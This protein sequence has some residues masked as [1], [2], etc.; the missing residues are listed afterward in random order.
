MAL[1]YKE[2]W[3]DGEQMGPLFKN[4]GL[5]DNSFVYDKPQFDPNECYMYLDYDENAAINKFGGTDT[6]YYDAMA[7][8]FVYP[9]Y[10]PD[11]AD[12]DPETWRS[13]KSIEVCEIGM[14]GRVRLQPEHVD[15]TDEFGYAPV[16]NARV[17]VILALCL[18]H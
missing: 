17:R 8:P 4:K 9:K 14:K 1:D 3:G 10:H 12:A 18:S 15:V 7:I 11:L 6:K 5:R 2:G 13:K 16:F